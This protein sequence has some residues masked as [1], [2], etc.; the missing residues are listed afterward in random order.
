MNKYEE[1]SD[2][3]INKLTAICLG[4]D[5]LAS[6]CGRFLSVENKMFDPCNNS[7]DAWPIMIESKIT[8]I[9]LIE[10]HFA[11]ANLEFLDGECC[12]NVGEWTHEFRD[13]NPLRAA[14]VVFLMMKDGEQCN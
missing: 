4:L 7:N 2:F 9:D 3:E 14:M 1:K 6:A 8:T 11:V 10:E 12:D 5:Y 13:K